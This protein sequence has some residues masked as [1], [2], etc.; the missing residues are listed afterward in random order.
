[1]ANIQS[2]L[3]QIKNAVF[4]KD[5]RESIHDAIKQCYDDAAVNHDNANMEVKLARGTHDTLNDRLVENEKNQENLSSQLDTNV[6][7]LDDKKA[8]KKDTN[9]IQQQVN[10]LVLEAVGDGNNAEVIQARNSIFGNFTVL[11]EH[12]DV[13]GNALQKYSDRKYLWQWKICGLSKDKINESQNWRISTPTIMYADENITVSIDFSKYEFGI[14]LFNSDGTFKEDLGWQ[15]SE[16]T[17]PLGSCFKISI[18]K[19]VSYEAITNIFTN[20]IY[21]SLNTTSKSTFDVCKLNSL[22]TDIDLAKKDMYLSE[23]NSIQERVNRSDYA[24]YPLVGLGQMSNVKLC[25][26]SHTDGVPKFD[27]SKNWRV[28][29]IDIMCFDKD[30]RI[31]LKDK[32]NYEYSVCTYSYDDINKKYTLLN[33]TGFITNDYIIN[34]GTHFMFSSQKKNSFTNLIDPKNNDVINNILFKIGDLKSLQEI[35]FELS[36]TNIFKYG[37]D[38]LKSKNC[39]KSKKAFDLV[40]S[41]GCQATNIID[42]EIWVWYASSNDPTGYKGQI[43]KFD[44]NTYAYKGDNTKIFHNLGHVPSVDYCN[45]NDTLIV[46]N[47]TTDTSVVAKLQLFKNVTNNNGTLY[48]DNPDYIEIDFSSLGSGSIATL[49][50]QFNIVYFAIAN[51][52]KKIYKVLLGTGENNFSDYYGTFKEGCSENEYNG[53]AKI[54]DEYDM[55]YIC[56]VIQTLVYNKGKIY[57]LIGSKDISICE[58]SLIDNYCKIENYI[59]VNEYDNNGAIVKYEP[60]GLCFDNNKVFISMFNDNERKVIEVD[61]SN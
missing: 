11:K 60:E 34:K 10:N 56:G 52:T 55:S 12:L 28:S 8:D 25:G 9:N 31:R 22:S 54:I 44:K 45:E 1:M 39:A 24:L 51:G 7:E 5:V 43:T 6:R 3:N 15:T 50:E 29:C 13:L 14:I 18:Q 53:T 16:Y 33:D 26:I 2:Y 41:S 57:L 36:D 58:L 46:S 23:Y 48:I 40:V 59:Q 32:I 38:L 37:L 47:G 49:G 27:Y 4:G 35:E 42:D 19:K 30:V 20:E 17:I 21:N 61:I